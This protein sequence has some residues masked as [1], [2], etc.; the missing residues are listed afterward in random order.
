[1]HRINLYWRLGA[2]LALL[3]IAA[4]IPAGLLARGLRVSAQ[5]EGVLPL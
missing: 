3:A 1:M 5:T 4:S 2:G